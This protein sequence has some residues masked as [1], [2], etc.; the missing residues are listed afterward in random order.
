[1]GSWCWSWGGALSAR[2]FQQVIGPLS[3]SACNLYKCAVLGCGE[4]A[5][6]TL[7]GEAIEGDMLL[8]FKVTDEGDSRPDMVHSCLNSLSPGW[9]FYQ[10][11]SFSSS[12][13]SVHMLTRSTAGEATRAKCLSLRCSLIFVPNPTWYIRDRI[14]SF[15]ALIAC[16]MQLFARAGVLQLVL[17]ALKNRYPPLYVW[18][19]Q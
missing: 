4:D 1:M 8:L 15:H 16:L 2:I 6:R 17:S 12:P 13:C 3:A 9:A 11:L 18:R 10:A 19:V 7:Q 14:A 5:A